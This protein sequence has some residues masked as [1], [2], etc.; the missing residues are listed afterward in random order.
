MHGLYKFAVRMLLN[1]DC[2]NGCRSLYRNRILT[3]KKIRT[4]CQAKFLTSRHVRMHRAI[5]YIS[6]TLIKLMIRAQGLVF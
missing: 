4:R 1:F 3:L 5:F 6:H 2:T